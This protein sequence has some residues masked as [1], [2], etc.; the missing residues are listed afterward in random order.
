MDSHQYTSLLEALAHVPD[1]RKAKGKE[2]EWRVVMAVLC[3]AVAGGQRSVRGIAQ[4]AKEHEA[5]LIHHLQPTRQ[6][7]PSAATLYRVMR[8]VDVASV[9]NHLAHFS[10]SQECARDKHN[11]QDN[12]RRRQQLV[13]GG[14]NSWGNR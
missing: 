10:Y 5:E 11:A 9:E 1:P 6:H 7:L 8:S 4:W 2:H 13:E 12:R 14:S 3:A